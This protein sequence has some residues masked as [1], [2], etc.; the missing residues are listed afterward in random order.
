M[1][2]GSAS[3]RAIDE[4][5]YRGLVARAL[6]KVIETDAENRAA[7]EIINRLSRN[8]AQRTCFA[9]LRPAMFPAQLQPRFAACALI[10][11]GDEKRSREETALLELLATLVEAYERERYPRQRSTPREMLE[12]LMESNDLKQADIGKIIGS[13]AHASEILNGKVSISKTQAKKL[14]ERFRVS[15]A[16]FL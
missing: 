11:R 7:L 4:R 8:S 12:F 13:R 5:R 1:S 9:R 2:A 15:Q 10:A 6:P 14:G 3:V 16:M